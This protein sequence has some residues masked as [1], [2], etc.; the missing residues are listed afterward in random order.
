MMNHPLVVVI[1][2][3][4][5][6]VAWFV[7]IVT[8]PFADEQVESL[9]P[10]PPEKRQVPKNVRLLIGTSVYDWALEEEHRHQWLADD[11]L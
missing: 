4:V 3:V 11:G 10:W 1:A 5:L 7:L 6:A 8:I 2:V 9:D